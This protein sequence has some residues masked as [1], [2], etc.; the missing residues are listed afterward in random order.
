MDSNCLSCMSNGR[1]GQ[2]IMKLF[3][4]ACLSYQPSNVT[5]REHLISRTSL[6]G[7]RRDLLD[8]VQQIM[9]SSELFKLNSIYPRRYF[10]DLVV[11]NQVEQDRI[12]KQQETG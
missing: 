10:D 6:I 1:D 7:M 5:Y 4:T 3:R 11:E 9:E 2:M 12:K 8:K